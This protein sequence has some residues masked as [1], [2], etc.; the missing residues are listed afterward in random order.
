MSRYGTPYR[1]RGPDLRPF[2]P[3]LVWLSIAAIVLCGLIGWAVGI[4]FARLVA[5]TTMVGMDATGHRPSHPPL[6]TSP[7]RTH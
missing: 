2:E 6:P 7:F 5:D 4:P 1:R 3:N